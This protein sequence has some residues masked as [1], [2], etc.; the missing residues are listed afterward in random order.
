M[1]TPTEQVLIDTMLSLNAAG[2]DQDAIILAKAIELLR[3]TGEWV[4][5]LRCGM[6]FPTAA[7]KST[8][9]AKAH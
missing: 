7:A 2:R 8:H 6:A 5:C 1:N 4:A 9:Y 3:E